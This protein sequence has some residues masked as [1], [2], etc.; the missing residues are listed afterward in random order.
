VDD[1]ERAVRIEELECEQLRIDLE[2]QSLRKQGLTR[3]FGDLLGVAKGMFPANLTDEE[4]DSWK[5]AGDDVA[6]DDASAG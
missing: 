2:L 6:W 3:H 1:Q 5:Y 4:I